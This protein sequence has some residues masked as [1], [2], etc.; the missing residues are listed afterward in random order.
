MKKKFAWFMVTVLAVGVFANQSSKV[1]VHPSNQ[2]LAI[3]QELGN[4][5]PPPPP[6]GGCG[7]KGSPCL[8]PTKVVGNG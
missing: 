2:I 6:R 4:G 3:A 5:L 1:Q 8:S 7:G